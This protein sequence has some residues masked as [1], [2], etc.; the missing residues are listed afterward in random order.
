[1][2]GSE[3]SDGSF[4][5]CQ[6]SGHPDKALMIR[7]S[8]VGVG[9]AFLCSL[10]LANFLLVSS[11]AAQGPSR[12]PQSNKQKKDECS[13]AGTVVKLAGSEPLTKAIVRLQS[14][15]DRTRAISSVTNAG[16]RFELRRD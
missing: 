16:G 12:D 14:M 11:L 10:A 8:L 3:I 9:P 5:S 7:C 4:F 6:S 2:W 13:I 1:M 15:E